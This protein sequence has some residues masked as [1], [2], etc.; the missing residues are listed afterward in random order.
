[1]AHA[2]SVSWS[3]TS[4]PEARGV[5]YRIATQ[6]SVKDDLNM[7]HISDYYAEYAR[8]LLMCAASRGDGLYQCQ[9]LTAAKMTAKTIRAD[10]DYIPI[11]DYADRG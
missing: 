2:G 9:H 4:F 5:S 8:R 11:D 6:T 1:M 3:V 7:S 10:R